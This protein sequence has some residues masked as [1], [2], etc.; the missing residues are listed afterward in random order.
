MDGRTGGLTNNHFVNLCEDASNIV[1]NN[2]S[3]YRR[4]YKWC[5]ETSLSGH[6]YTNLDET[7][8]VTQNKYEQRFKVDALP[9]G[10]VTLP[11]KLLSLFGV[12]VD[13]LHHQFVTSGLSLSNESLH[14]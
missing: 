10:K 5:Y 9:I 7:G 14:I 8:N 3:V 11:S 4:S 13:D 1:C 2:S 6:R 12:N